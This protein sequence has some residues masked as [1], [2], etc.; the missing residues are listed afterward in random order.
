MEDCNLK[1]RRLMERADDLQVRI[2]ALKEE[3]ERL[4]EEAE[5]LMMA[6]ECRNER[7]TDIMDTQPMAMLI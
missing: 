1:R 5:M 7:T 6:D 4:R 2:R 3:E